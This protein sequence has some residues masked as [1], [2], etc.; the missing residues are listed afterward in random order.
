MSKLFCNTF[1]DAFM[2]G[3]D[4]K[5]ELLNL[6][7]YMSTSYPHISHIFSDFTD[8]T[9]IID[10]FT[11]IGKF[12]SIPFKVVER[13][14][15]DEI[16]KDMTFRQFFTELKTMNVHQNI[17][18]DKGKQYS[19][20]FHEEE[21]FDHLILTGLITCVNAIKMN[22]DPFI[23]S[24]SGILH[25]IGKPGCIHLFDK[26]HVGYRYNGEFGSLIL[27]RIDSSSFETF[28]SKDSWE[29]ICRLTT[30]HMCSYHLTTFISPWEQARLNSTRIENDLTKQYLMALSY[31][32]VFS[33]LSDKTSYTDFTDS[34]DQY[35]TEI[36][37][38]FVCN[39]NKF[40]ITVDGLSN[41]G[42]STIADILMSFFS[43]NN[44]SYG[45]IARD[46]I[47]CDLVMRMQNLSL[48]NSRPTA[49]EYAECYTYYKK[50]GLS[51]IVNKNM[52][53]TICN[54]INS[55]TVTI[56]DT[57][58]TLF[59]QTSSI[60]PSNISDCIIISIDVNRNHITID[61]KKNGIGLNDQLSLSGS[62]TFLKP[63]DVK[64]MDVYRLQS[65]YCS[66][67]EDLTCTCGVDFKFQVCS[68]SEFYDSNSIGLDTFKDIFQRIY[69]MIDMSSSSGP[70]LDNLNLTD[71]VNN[72]YNSVDKNYDKLTEFFR[73]KAYQCA[74]PIDFRDTSYS[75]RIIHL[76][77]LDHNNNWNKWGRDTRGTAFYL[78]DEQFWIPVKYLMQRGAEMLTGMQIRRGITDTE[79]INLSA[80][81]R[82]SHLSAGQQSLIIKLAT[83][84]K[85][86][87]KASFKKD[88]SLHAFV[89][90]S[91]EFAKV[92][93]TVILLK[94][95]EFTKTVMNI[96]DSI[97]GTTDYTFVFQ[98][99]GTMLLG[100]FMQDYA[101]TAL[102]P[103]ADPK[104]TP[105]K[106]IS[107]YGSDLFRRLKNIFDE[108]SG[109]F[110]FI[111]AETICRNR[112]ESYSGKVHN[113]LAVSYNESGFTI[114]S[115]TSI[116]D[117][118]YKV[119]PHYEFSELINS[120]GFNE[121]AFWDVTT[122]EMMD[123]LIKAVDSY[124]FGKMT[125]NEFYEFY[126]PSNKYEY[127]KIIDVEGFVVYDLDNSN[128][129]GKIK[130]DSYYKAHKLRENNISF[131]CDLA[132]VAGHL[133]PLAQ[134]V[135]SIYVG[136]DSKLQIINAKLIELITS[137]L[138]VNA[139]NEKARKSYV[140]KDKA[141]QFKIIINTAKEVYC[142]NAI[143]FFVEQ[144]GDI[145]VT[146]DVKSA[147]VTY[148]MKCEI[149]R[150]CPLSP[151]DDFRSMLISAMIG[152]N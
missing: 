112:L 80:D 113:E 70:R 22:L 95:D 97:S 39:R 119:D 38:P 138:M 33:A 6:I 10:T 17:I 121:P 147:L 44:I 24:L 135:R 122:V 141:T 67:N 14:E 76:K 34:R 57:Q 93:R 62:S 36:S 91:G 125:I 35:Y 110:K 2:S 11:K 127:P 8:L 118:I 48:K 108:M 56:I 83:G 74:C 90:Y 143:P 46:N 102:F 1:F 81:Y 98:S 9:K 85:V 137:E 148:A 29:M 130:T 66:K 149:W 132:L 40:V 84:N 47:M 43:D 101:T 150:D 126:P 88:G 115:R 129:Y 104:L 59:K 139:L 71:L 99:Q 77:Y 4:V 52:Q 50:N 73:T 106:K 100:N 5:H 13:N 114:L 142:S 25:D 58:M 55:N 63:F 69:S 94:A 68:N 53:N 21:L 37:K 78:N 146:D 75:K 27:S 107:A 151:P 30:I 79:N 123:N 111:L 12:F 72:V 23:S 60:F 7:S 136:L 120:N 32:D 117:S 3:S 26:G 15:K 124:I 49:N 128:S 109:D 18:D 41:S 54:S 42:K 89:L 92:M 152:T 61:D 28:I 134:R 131:L 65:K 45:Y 82:C 105:I 144:F 31:G 20:G 87:L 133:F 116:E 19:C 64:S 140:L 16:V 145:V 86:N 96:W 51:K 103:M